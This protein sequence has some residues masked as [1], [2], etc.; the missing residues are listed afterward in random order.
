MLKP[1]TKTAYPYSEYRSESFNMPLR[2]RPITLGDRTQE[3]IMRCDLIKAN[4][5]L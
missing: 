3:I 2:G 5:E 1:L 4:C